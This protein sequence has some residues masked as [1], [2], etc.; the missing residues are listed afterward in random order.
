MT[1]VNTSYQRGYGI[2]FEWSARNGHITDGLAVSSLASYINM[3]AA[4][5]MHIL[6]QGGAAVTGGLGGSSPALQYINASTSPNIAAVEVLTICTPFA[7]TLSPANFFWNVNGP[8]FYQQQARM[9]IGTNAS[10][11]AGPGSVVVLKQRLVDDTGANLIG[12][13][14]YSFDVELNAASLLYYVI[15]EVPRTT[16]NTATHTA[17]PTDVFGVG[18]PIL[19]R[20]VAT[21]TDAM[22]KIYRRQGSPCFTWAEDL[23][24]GASRAG[25][26]YANIL[27]GSTAG[28]SSSAA[29]FWTI[30]YRKNRMTGSTVNVVLWATGFVSAGTGGRVRFSNSSGVIG[31]IT[32]YTTAKL[33]RSTTATLDATQT[34][35][36]VT[37]EISDSGLNTMN[38]Q[39]AG[40][41]EY[42]T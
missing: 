25:T 17:I 30:P 41:Y 2:P 22:W 27:S 10:G 13:T 3:I 5:R 8:G 23:G 34:S 20:D 38:C 24:I 11:A 32:G 16:L 36:L 31:T 33:Q 26:T 15:Y 1:I 7:G 18:A 39:T 6:A 28:Y 40:M 42:M 21:M 14:Q 37:V 4:R 9:Y 35:D 12:D 19:D 29:G